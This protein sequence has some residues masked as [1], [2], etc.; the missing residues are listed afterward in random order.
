MTYIVGVD[1]AV[2]AAILEIRVKGDSGGWARR[3]GSV[4]ARTTIARV[5]L[6]AVQIGRAGTQAPHCGTGGVDWSLQ[7]SRA[8]GC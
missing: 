1:V 4:T 8:V 5:L 6:V 2:R 3:R 7:G